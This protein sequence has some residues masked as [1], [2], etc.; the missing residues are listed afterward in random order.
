MGLILLVFGG[1]L[2]IYLAVRVTEDRLSAQAVEEYRKQQYV[3]AADKFKQLQQQFS[4]SDRVPEYQMLEDLCLLRKDLEDMQ[5]AP[6]VVLPQTESF[7]QRHGK[8]PV[9]KDYHGDL[10]QSLM[11]R[12]SELS[13]QRLPAT[14][15]PRPCSKPW[16]K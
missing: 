13:N 7:L 1:A 16:G 2:A 11:R 12:L 6:A 4:T 15:K 10:G 5:L 14:R 9:L 3:G 8:L